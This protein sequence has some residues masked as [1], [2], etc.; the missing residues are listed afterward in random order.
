MSSFFILVLVTRNFYLFF[1]MWDRRHTLIWFL[2]WN[3]QRTTLQLKNSS[4]G[5][6]G[7]INKSNPH[8]L[9]AYLLKTEWTIYLV[10]NFIFHLNKNGMYIC[11][12]SFQ[13]KKMY[14]IN[15]IGLWLVNEPEL[16]CW[17]DEVQLIIISRSNKYNLKIKIRK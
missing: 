8:L 13:M 2:T 4:W 12:T 11:F 10:H 7:K 14:I 1:N 6:G 5:G 17:W 15:Y 3:S 16:I 9:Y